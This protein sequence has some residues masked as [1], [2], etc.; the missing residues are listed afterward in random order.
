[1]AAMATCS[2]SLP[3]EVKFRRT[4]SLAFAK[5][6]CHTCSSLGI[7]CDRQ[8]PRCSPCQNAGI[9]CQGYSMKLTW[10]QNHSMSN[11]P[12]KVKTT[13]P[14]AF[15]QRDNSKATLGRA[16]N[17]EKSPVSSATTTDHGRQFMFVA[18]R[19][20]KRRK[21]NH[22]STESEAPSRARASSKISV[23]GPTRK[24]DAQASLEPAAR[25][26]SNVTVADTLSTENASEDTIQLPPIPDVGDFN[27]DPS[28]NDAPVETTPWQHDNFNW[29][30]PPCQQP[31]EMI[32]FE[33]LAQCLE[34]QQQPLDVPI[35]S[36]S[37]QV[38]TNMSLDLSRD[39][40]TE[41]WNDGS[42]ADGQTDL[43]L[44]DIMF[45][46]PPQICYSTL[47]D[48]F[49]G[50]LDMCMF[51]FVLITHS[52]EMTWLTS[53]VGDKKTTKNS[54]A[55]R[56]PT[57]S[58]S[59]LIVTDPKRREARSTFCMPSSRCRATSDCARP[60]SPNRRPTQLTIRTRPWCCIRARCP[61]R[62]F[63][64]TV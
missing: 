30:S 58:R 20:P 1:M 63:T 29:I 32:D 6:D 43:V 41:D 34:I 62:T 8:R 23:A 51:A 56:S 55:I 11:R 14:Q 19:A 28:L 59:I 48:K 16:L 45:T 24:P 21:K 33:S 64:S 36:P 61:R 5:S 4:N 54:V 2:P 46:T 10:H 57:T 7:H 9:L 53:C 31:S 40:W 60:R 37:M 12:P 44:Q 17:K 42:S 22:Q 50:L 47:T 35:P 3:S 39:L 13:P 38:S 18:A 15:D 26:S 27:L 52:F 49:Y 25:R